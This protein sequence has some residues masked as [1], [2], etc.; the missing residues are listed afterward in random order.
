MEIT[1]IK[2]ITESV[3]GLIGLES[4]CTRRGDGSGYASDEGLE[5]PFLLRVERDAAGGAFR[6]CNVHEVDLF[7]K[8]IAATVL[9]L[10]CIPR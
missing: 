3:F 7:S 2:R 9:L 4:I 1:Y 6:H 10:D 5:L 8:Q